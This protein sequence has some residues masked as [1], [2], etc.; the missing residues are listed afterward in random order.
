MLWIDYTVESYPDGS[1]TVK[2]DWDGEVMGKQKDGSDKD[3]FLYKPGDKFV[4]DDKGILR[5]V[6]A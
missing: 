6:E 1:F 2:G 3:H 4:V 5:K